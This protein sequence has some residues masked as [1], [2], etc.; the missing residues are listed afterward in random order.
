MREL[1]NGVQ[2]LVP[3]ERLIVLDTLSLRELVPSTLVLDSG[4]PVPAGK[5]QQLWL[6]TK[7]L[8]KYCGP[9]FWGVKPASMEVSGL[10]SWMVKRLCV[11]AK[12]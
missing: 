5:C 10:V 1:P 4:N 8:A 12:A 11:L 3:Q 2:S 7:P 6:W 9:Q